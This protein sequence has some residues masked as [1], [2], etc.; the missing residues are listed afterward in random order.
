MTPEIQ[1]RIHLLG[2]RLDAIKA[3]KKHLLPFVKLLHDD[4]AH[5]DDPAYSRYE[6][7]PHHE[8]IAKTLEKIE[9]GKLTRVI[10]SMPPRHGKTELVTKSF[11][12]WYMGRNPMNSV[13]GAT[14]SDQFAGDLGREIKSNILHPAFVQTFDQMTLKSDSKAANRMMND[15]GGSIFM[16]GRNS[17][18]TGRGGHLIV[19]DDPIKNRLEADS[20]TVREGLWTWFT[21]VLMTRLMTDTSSILIVQTRWHED[22]L[23]GRLTDPYNPKYDPREAAKWHILDLPAL[24]G[25]KDP[26]KRQPGEALWPERFGVDYLTSIQNTDPRGF[27]A[28]YQG[29]PS[30]DTGAFFEE[31]DLQVYG[32]LADLPKNLRWYIAS[33]HAVSTA[34]DADYTCMIPVGVDEEGMIWVSPEVWWK[35][36]DTKTVVDAMI[37]LIKRFKPLFWWAE[38]GHITKSIGPFLRKEMVERQAICALH[39]VQPTNDKLQRAQSIHGR[40]SLGRVRFPSFATWWPDAKRQ[41]LQFPY[42]ANDDFVDTLSLIGLGLQMQVHARAPAK[43]EL[44]SPPVGTLSWVKWQSDQEKKTLNHHNQTSG[45]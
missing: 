12:P 13:I 40:I 16:V 19:L 29:K 18:I 44:D 34:Q 5:S 39:E 41:M 1:A 42:G 27:S 25:K 45:W 15:K 9:A 26:L 8:L 2:R 14:Y 11:I 3:A 37:H 7:K 36:A 17:A 21:Q 22:D 20:K 35:R 4:P 6:V 43:K 31:R 10:I 23:I 38:K 28:L 30:A 33:D 24:A 32:S